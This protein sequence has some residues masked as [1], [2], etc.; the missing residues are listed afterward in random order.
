MVTGFM[1]DKNLR[2]SCCV[3]MSVAPENSYSHVLI[4]QL[5]LKTL[6]AITEVLYGIEN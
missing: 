2:S 1:I 5:H 4:C 3:N 6:T